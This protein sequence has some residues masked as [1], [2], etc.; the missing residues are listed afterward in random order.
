M[1]EGRTGERQAERKGRASEIM[2]EHWRILMSVASLVLLAGA[3]LLQLSGSSFLSAPRDYLPAFIIAYLPVGLP[4]VYHACKDLKEGN[5]FNEFLLMS[6]ASI[7]AFFI[8]EYPEAV[9]VML[10]YCIGEYLQ[11]RAVGRSRRSIRSL[12]E[13]SP[14]TARVKAD[15][16]WV[17]KDSKDVGIGEE[18]MMKAGER[19]A[20]DGRLLSDSATFD[21]SALTGE[22]VPLTLRQGSQVRAGMI[23]MGGTAR[24]EVTHLL[25]DSAPARILRMVEEATESKAPTETFVRRFARIY[26]PT[27]IG[28]AV[29]IAFVPTLVTGWHVFN[30]YLYRALMFL[31][32]SCPCALVLSVPLSYFSG[33]GLAARRGILFKGGN[34]LDS[35]AK[36]DTVVFDKTGTLT[37]G[38]MKVTSVRTSPDSDEPEVLTVMA[39]AEACSTHP[40][41]LALIR[42]AQEKG[43]KVGMADDTKEIPGKG[44]VMETPKGRVFV[45]NPSALDLPAAGSSSGLE[46]GSKTEI[47]YAVNGEVKA[48]VEFADE[49]RPEATTAMERLRTVG[50]GTIGIIS[51]DRQVIVDRLAQ[52]L[53]ADLHIGSCLPE[54]KARHI[55][56][57]SRE[58]TGGVV[59]VGDGINDAPALAAADAGV[60]MGGIGSDAAI[61]TADV[62]IQ[63]DDLTKVESAI[64]IG[65]F[66]RRLAIGN[67]VIALAAKGIFLCLGAAGML[68][69]WWAVFADT[70]VAL[71]CVANVLIAQALYGRK[72]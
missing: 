63:S 70:G 20:L 31:V 44:V 34:F 67:I 61:E 24:V 3:V 53:G 41:A 5:P 4:V 59:F 1:T 65:R 56:A 37:K 45:G 43:A 71:I 57:L 66:T 68:N 32:I 12:L 49:L 40:L 17:T 36:A 47:V 60:A 23:V 22:S 42:Y 16:G 62:V 10:F 54:D 69:L 64:G 15:E 52:E 55:T 25:E 27:V 14:E 30:D 51:G 26:T 28:L 46:D 11:D 50:I 18:I 58:G 6:V 38:R 39:T 8:G 13:L 19:V 2:E 48:V 29:A 35:I 72:C 7:G 21:S 9:G 33:I